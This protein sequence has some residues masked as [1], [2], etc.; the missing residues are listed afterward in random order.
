MNDPTMTGLHLTTGHIHTRQHSDSEYAR[1]ASRGFPLRRLRS[2]PTGA[3]TIMKSHP[4]AEILLFSL[5]QPIML[6]CFFICHRRSDRY[7]REPP[8]YNSFLM[9]EIFAQTSAHLG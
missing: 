9:A 3:D 4:R 5:N 1:N 2:H 7:N 8:A 6:C